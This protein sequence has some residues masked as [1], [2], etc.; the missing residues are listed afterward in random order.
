RGA[1]GNPWLFRDGRA[2]LDGQPASPPPTPAERFGVALD[3]ARLALRLQGDT[4][5]TVVEFRKH[6]G[7]YTRGLH[8]AGELRQRLFRIESIAEAEAIFLEYL[9]PVPRWRESGA[10]RSPARRRR[11]RASCAGR[12]ARTPAPPS[13]RRSPVRQDRSPSG[14][15]AGAARGR[16]L[17]GQDAGAGRRHL[18]AARGG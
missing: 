14:P 15:P 13:L 7:W 16:V 1:F 5:K 17:R 6:L 12:G 8:G 11:R 3:H 4:R 10:A 18:R 9:E 2:R